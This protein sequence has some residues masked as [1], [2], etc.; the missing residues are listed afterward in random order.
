ML[1]VCLLWQRMLSVQLADRVREIVFIIDDIR[2][3]HLIWFRHIRQLTEQTPKSD[4]NMGTE[5]KEKTRQADKKLERK[6]RHRMERKRIQ[7][8]CIE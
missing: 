1:C 2:N 5:R 3:K 8:S 6:Y 7:G 4:P